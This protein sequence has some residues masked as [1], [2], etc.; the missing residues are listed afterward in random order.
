M[1]SVI[2]VFIWMW[3]AFVCHYGYVAL[4][5][6][7]DP[8]TLFYVCTDANRYLWVFHGLLHLCVCI[9]RESIFFHVLCVWRCM[10]MTR[11]FIHVYSYVWVGVYLFYIDVI[12]YL[13]VTIHL[14]NCVHWHDSLL[15][16]FDKRGLSVI[17]TIFYSLTKILVV[18][19]AS[20]YII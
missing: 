5:M 11:S 17:I 10:K 13:W 7:N 19:Y 12:C 16:C 20:A 2:Y 15:K 8:N 9:K 18:S 4:F 3:R 14:T 1:F 6:W